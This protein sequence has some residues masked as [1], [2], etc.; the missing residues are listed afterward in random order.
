VK[1]PFQLPFGGVFTVYRAHVGGVRNHGPITTYGVSD[2]VIDRSSRECPLGVIFFRH[3]AP[4]PT[5]GLPSKAE[6]S[7]HP[8]KSGS[9]SLDSFRAGRMPVTEGVGHH[10]PLRETF[11]L[12]SNCADTPY[13][14]RR[15]IADGGG[16]PRHRGVYAVFAG[17]A[18]PR[19]QRVRFNSIRPCFSVVPSARFERA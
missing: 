10:R 18:R 15:N 13:N 3:N 11:P 5:T 1:A 6:R 2:M 19:R 8:E 17:H 9:L 14:R 16:C 7:G 12:G 4:P